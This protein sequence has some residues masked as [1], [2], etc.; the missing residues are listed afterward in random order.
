V[1]WLILL[2]AC[3]C[4]VAGTLTLKVTDGMTRLWPT[5]LMFA[6]YLA[7]LFGLSLALRQIPVGTAYAVW[8]A[9]GTL[10]VFAIGVLWF[11]EPLT[12]LRLMFTAFIVVGVSGLYLTGLDL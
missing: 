9:L 3:L 11:K 2:F 1:S 6:L 10:V 5:V 7:S 8:S 12:L 4:E